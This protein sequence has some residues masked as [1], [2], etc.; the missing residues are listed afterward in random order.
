M[1]VKKTELE[2]VIDSD[3]NITAT[4]ICGEGGA[5]CLGELDKLMKGVGVTTKESKNKDFYK[6]QKLGNRLAVGG[7]KK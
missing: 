2:V 5:S 4:V 1:R 6:R 3:G 7:R